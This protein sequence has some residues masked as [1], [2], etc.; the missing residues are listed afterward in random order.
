[1]FNSRKMASGS[2]RICLGSCKAC[3]TT[4]RTSPCPTFKLLS[5]HFS[6]R[7]KFSAQWTLQHARKRPSRTRTAAI[8]A[9]TD[10]MRLVTKLWELAGLAAWYIPKRAV[11]STLSSRKVG[12]KLPPASQPICRKSQRRYPLTGRT[13]PS[14]SL[15]RRA[16]FLTPWPSLHLPAPAA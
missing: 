3:L 7:F 2:P 16:T 15:C 8:S 10:Q 9:T 12:S 4:N 14:K 13:C 1:M 6:R 5:Q 11:N